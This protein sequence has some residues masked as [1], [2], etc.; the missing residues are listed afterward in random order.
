MALTLKLQSHLQHGPPDS[1]LKA[2][3]S[4]VARGKAQIVNPWLS[5]YPYMD[6]AAGDIQG[7][8]F[9]MADGERR[10]YR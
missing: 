4:E 7:R 2:G 10:A 5:S 8:K 6:A 9:V 1:F 3:S